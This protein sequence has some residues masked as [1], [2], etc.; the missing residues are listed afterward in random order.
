MKE[1]K[2]KIK[3]PVD[4]LKY[5]DCPKCGTELQSKKGKGYN[6]CPKCSITYTFQVET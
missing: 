5:R 1:E 4:I 3:I 2:I 6:F